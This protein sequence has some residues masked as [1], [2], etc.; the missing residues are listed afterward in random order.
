[1]RRAIVWLVVAGSLASLAACGSSSNNVSSNE[2]NRLV[3]RERDV[4]LG[5]SS[6]YFGRQARLDTAGTSRSDPARFGRQGGWIARYHRAGS[7]KSRG[8]LVIESRADVFGGS[9]GARS[10]LDAYRRDFAIV[11]GTQVRSFSVT[12]LGTEAA[13]VT[14]VQPGALPVRSYSI[15][16]RDRNV[17]ASVTV[18]GFDGRFDRAAAVRLA[19]A[20]ERLI[21]GA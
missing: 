9:R 14:W 4:G 8:P 11:P 6:F 10:E 17:A 3:L 19:R 18:Q 20:Q 2:L 21:A 16:W 13:G 15:A 5:F 12:Q 1:V 7:A